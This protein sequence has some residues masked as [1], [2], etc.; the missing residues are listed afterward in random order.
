MFKKK[1]YEDLLFYKRIMLEK[2][3]TF[4]ECMDVNRFRL[5]KVNYSC[6]NFLL[7]SPYSP[8]ALGQKRPQPRKKM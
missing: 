4:Q 2:T 5:P 1:T 8:R 6:G 3:S 7:Y